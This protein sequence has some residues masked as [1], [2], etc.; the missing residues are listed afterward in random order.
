MSRVNSPQSFNFTCTH[1]WKC[2]FFT[3]KI[4]TQLDQQKHGWTWLSKIQIYPKRLW[5]MCIKGKKPDNLFFGSQGTNSPSKSWW[6]MT[7]TQWTTTEVTN[8]TSMCAKLLTAC[9]ANNLVIFT[10]WSDKIRK[11]PQL[12]R[13]R[14][15]S[16]AKWHCR[17]TNDSRKIFDTQTEVI[18]FP[19]D[20][21]S[22]TPAITRC[23]G[24]LETSTGRFITR[25]VSFGWI[26]LAVN[27]A[28]TENTT[29]ILS[30]ASCAA[31]REQAMGFPCLLTRRRNAR[32]TFPGTPSWPV[33]SG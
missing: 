14:T 16:G 15:F 9:A 3:S 28:T 29:E 1:D 23:F 22:T 25:T 12:H 26:T 18:V 8:L 2:F 24:M 21:V 7:R 17:T 31:R 5:K 4:S 33:K 32:T 11:Q 6:R 13:K 19:Q 20:H 30:S 27:S 10:N